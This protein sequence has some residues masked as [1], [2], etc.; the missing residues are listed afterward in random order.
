MENNKSNEHIAKISI[1]NTT[2]ADF[3]KQIDGDIL[4]FILIT[5]LL[6]IFA[7]YKLLSYFLP[8]E[9]FK[10]KE[11]GKTKWRGITHFYQEL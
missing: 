8:H 4:S 3:A 2:S 7:G 6:S 1:P 5:L 10:L 9:Y 11:K